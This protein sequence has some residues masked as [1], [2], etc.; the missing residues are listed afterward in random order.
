ML[1]FHVSDI[2][3]GW[4]QLP[5]RRCQSFEKKNAHF[6]ATHIMQHKHSL[7]I[8]LLP[9]DHKTNSGVVLALFITVPP[10]WTSPTLLGHPLFIKFHCHFAQYRQ[11]MRWFFVKKIRRTFF[12][13]KIYLSRKIIQKM[14]RF[15]VSY[16]HLRRNYAALRCCQIYDVRLLIIGVLIGLG[17]IMDVLN[18]QT[19]TRQN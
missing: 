1:Q 6:R 13:K 10:P 2:S 9:N 16:M 15:H 18:F 12:Y 3:R 5:L 7:L 19:I 4:N 17:D 8:I 14:L 11:K